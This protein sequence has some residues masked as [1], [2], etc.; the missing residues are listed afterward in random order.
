MIELLAKYAHNVEIAVSPF[1]VH[2]LP[3][4]AFEPETG[5]FIYPICGGILGGHFQ[6]DAVKIEGLEGIMNH[7]AG[8]FGAKSAGPVL[9]IGNTQVEC[10]HPAHP[11]DTHECGLSDRFE[12]IGATDGKQ[13]GIGIVNLLFGFLALLLLAGW[14]GVKQGLTRI[15]MVF[16]PGNHGDV[17]GFGSAEKNTFT[18]QKGGR[19]SHSCR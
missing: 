4:G 11:I 18:L 7:E 12:G 6:L 1:V 5:L 9:F 15:G 16:E 14:K 19:R 13:D 2:G 10:A 3:E 8:G 17:G